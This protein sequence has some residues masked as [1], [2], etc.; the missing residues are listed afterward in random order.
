M[1]GPSEQAIRPRH[2]PCKTGLPYDICYTCGSRWPCDTGKAL[3]TIDARDK[4]IAKWEWLVG[5]LKDELYCRAEYKWQP[6]PKTRP[7]ESWCD[8]C[9]TMALT[10]DDAPEE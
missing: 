2:R 10:V 9:R 1:N 3:A 6:C 5:E 7:K 8:A 4:T